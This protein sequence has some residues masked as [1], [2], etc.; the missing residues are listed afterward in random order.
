MVLLMP[1]LRGAALALALLALAPA[2]ASASAVHT[3]D[4][5][6]TVEDIDSGLRNVIS[7]EV[8]GS[9]VVVTEHDSSAPALTDADGDCEQTAVRVVTCQF[10]GTN[11]VVRLGGGDDEMRAGTDGL[12]REIHGDDGDDV[13]HGAI[14]G[15]VFIGGDGRDTVSYSERGE[16]D[17]VTVVLPDPDGSTPEPETTTDNGRPG[18]ADVIHDDVE[19]VTGGFGEDVITGNDLANRLHGFSVDGAGGADVLSSEADGTVEGGSGDDIVEV[20]DF[21]RQS[22]LDCGPGDDRINADNE[23]DATPLDCESIAPEFMGRPSLIDVN[24][25]VGGGA[26]VAIPDVSG[27][28]ITSFEIVWRRCEIDRCEIVSAGNIGSVHFG[29]EDVQWQFYAAVSVGNAAGSASDSTEFTP[30][31][32][33]PAEVPPGGFFFPP[34]PPDYRDYGDYGDYADYLDPLRTLE[35]GIAGRLRNLARRFSGR[36]PRTFARAR[37]IGHPFY[38]ASVG[39]VTL[40]WTAQRPGARGRAAASRRIVIARGTRRGSIG[41]IRSVPVKPTKRG[42]RILRRSKRLRVTLSARFV[43]GV[44]TRAVPATAKRTFRLKRR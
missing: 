28:P 13:L 23:L 19:D 15:D 32:S 18:E 24:P 8:D 16:D 2:A 5:T 33:A 41:Q 40:T 38:F 30:P 6:L 10:T 27:G 35:D 9:E 12:Q 20:E 39:T 21:V 4:S 36:D 17:P 42:R 3:S 22:S 25:T 14:E 34:P 11:A 7:I 31:I 1:I 37:T 43:G 26:I 44:A 29:P